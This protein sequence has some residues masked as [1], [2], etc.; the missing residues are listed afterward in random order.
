MNTVAGLR[1]MIRLRRRS[2]WRF[3]RPARLDAKVHPSKLHTILP[4]DARLGR[5]ARAAL[6]PWHVP[7]YFGVQKKPGQPAVAELSGA[8]RVTGLGYPSRSWFDAG[9]DTAA[10]WF[11]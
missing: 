9:D 7:R 5:S 6:K 11:R 1:V 2:P 3:H 10:G 4:C 8:G